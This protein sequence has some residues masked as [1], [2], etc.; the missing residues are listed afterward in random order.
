MKV[1]AKRPIFMKFIIWNCSVKDG[2][3]EKSCCST[4]TEKGVAQQ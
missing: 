1:L 4:E 2:I 3:S